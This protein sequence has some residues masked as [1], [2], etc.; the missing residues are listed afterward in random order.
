VLQIAQPAAAGLS[1]PEIDQW[2]FISRRT[3]GSHIV[4]AG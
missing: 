1:N 4:K 2:L 3:V